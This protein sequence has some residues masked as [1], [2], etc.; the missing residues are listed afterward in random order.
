MSVTWQCSWQ[1]KRVAVRR[2]YAPVSELP[3]RLFVELARDLYDEVDRR[4]C[5]A[6]WLGANLDRQAVP[7]LP[8][9]RPR[10]L[11][12]DGG[13]PEGLRNRWCDVTPTGS[14]EAGSADGSGICHLAH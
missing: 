12:S 6:V 4:E 13:C 9:P 1:T 2:V 10:M 14:A 5:E 7:F 8:R 3:E 11:C